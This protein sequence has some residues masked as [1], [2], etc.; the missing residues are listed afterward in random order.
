MDSENNEGESGNKFLKRIQSKA[1][2]T[3]LLSGT[4]FLSSIKSLMVLVKSPEAKLSEDEKK[5]RTPLIVLHSI[6][7]ALNVVQLTIILVFGVGIAAKKTDNQVNKKTYSVAKIISNVL[8]A[9]LLALQFIIMV[10]RY[11]EDPSVFWA[12][13][14]QANG[15]AGK[16]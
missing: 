12:P 10:I 14:D 3:G 15:T 13:L 11:D 6:A 5:F 4:F 16:L 2:S 9:L 8:S 1:T 7:I